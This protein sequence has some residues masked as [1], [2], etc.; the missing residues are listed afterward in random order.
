MV[1][2][3]DGNNNNITWCII[4]PPGG[5]IDIAV[6]ISFLLESRGKYRQHVSKEKTVYL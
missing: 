2:H 1:A 3:T 4:N 6:C 5:I